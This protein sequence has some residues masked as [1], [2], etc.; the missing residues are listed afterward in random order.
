[1]ANIVIRS[2]EGLTLARAASCNISV[3]VLPR[4]SVRN[5]PFQ[6]A[7]SGCYPAINVCL[8]LPRMIC[9]PS[10]FRKYIIYFDKLIW[11]STRLKT[12]FRSL[13]SEL[14]TASDADKAGG[15]ANQNLS[16]LRIYLKY[17]NSKLRFN[18]DL[19]VAP[20]TSP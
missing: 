8:F 11:I 15:R 2:D 9:T 13:L 7:R 14:A 3:P 18:F 1:M 12:R 10:L 6:L 16:T 17:F 19:S 20:P 5:I 4:F